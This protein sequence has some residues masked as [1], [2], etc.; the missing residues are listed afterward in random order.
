[1]TG[2]IIPAFAAV[3]RSAAARVQGF[4]LQ[5]LAILVG[6][7]KQHVRNYMPDIFGLVTDLW[8]TAALQLPLVVL[9]EALGR[10]LDAE[11]KP[12]LP[13][14]LPLMLKAFD[15]ELSDKRSVTQMKVFDAFL[16]FGANIEE[17]LH[18]V[19]PIIVTTYERA[20][21][22]GAL[23]KRAV[24]TINS[25]S[26]RVNFTDHA[27]RIIH[28]LVRVLGSA[29]NELRQAIM[30]TLCSLVIQLDSD[31]AIFVPSIDKV[32]AVFR[33]SKGAGVDGVVGPQA[34][35]VQQ[36]QV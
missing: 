18:L 23:R 4:H 1:M 34:H 17:Y 20:D 6:I 24:I 21:A 29:S 28:P 7:I 31:F 27:S 14:I 25:L 11:F 5:Q 13:T 3:T 12:F 33:L 2:Q 30:E 8:D 19:I 35:A 15:G 32:R 16:T 36:R 26:N 10:A 9:V 22:P